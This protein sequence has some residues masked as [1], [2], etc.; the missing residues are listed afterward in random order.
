MIKGFKYENEWNNISFFFYM[1][2]IN[3]IDYRS[4][5]CFIL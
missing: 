3:V 2:Y 1:G 4:V 5:N